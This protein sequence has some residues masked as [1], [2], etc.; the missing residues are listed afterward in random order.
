MQRS[1]LSFAVMQDPGQT[2]TLAAPQF[3][4][5]SDTFPLAAEP[6]KSLPVPQSDAAP[7]QVCNSNLPAVSSQHVTVVVSGYKV[8]LVFCYLPYDLRVPA[9]QSGASRVPRNRLRDKPSRVAFGRTAQ[10][11]VYIFQ[12]LTEPFV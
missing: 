3:A 12:V 5:G 11:E 9:T 6:G 8:D 2:K 1:H 7:E 4:T 10:S